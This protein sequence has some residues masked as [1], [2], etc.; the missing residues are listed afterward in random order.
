MV[1]ETYETGATVSLVA[2]RHGVAP[3]Q[4][5]GWRKLSYDKLNCYV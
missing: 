2:H 3:N 5:I 4:L 1:Q